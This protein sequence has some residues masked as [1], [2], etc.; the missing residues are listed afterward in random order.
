MIRS[1]SRIECALSRG[2]TRIGKVIEDAW[3]KGARFD[4]WTSLFNIDAWSVLFRK[5][6]LISGF[7]TSREYDA[8]EVLPWD[9]VDIGIKKEVSSGRLQKSP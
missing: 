7:Y 2:D 4:N 9:T 6:V 1:R 5:M 3:K 8:D